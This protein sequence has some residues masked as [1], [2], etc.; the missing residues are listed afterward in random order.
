MK[1]MGSKLSM[2]DGTLG[3]ELLR[4][5][6]PGG[7]F[8]DLFAGSGVVGRFVASQVDIPV[9]SVDLMRFSSLL[10]GATLERTKAL[11]GDALWRRWS[12][13]A[14]QFMAKHARLERMSMSLSRAA[15]EADVL[16]A[17]RLCASYLPDQFIWSH[18]GGYYFSPTQALQLSA[19]Y[20]TLPARAPHRTLALAAI[21][22]T[23]S[24]ASASPGHTA[25]P[26]RPTEKLLPH[27]RSAWSVDVREE[28]IRQVERMAAT[29]AKVRGLAHTGDGLEFAKK[30]IIA[31]DLVFCDPPYS[32]AQYG[33]FYHV[34]EGI[35]VGGWPAV[36][37]AG[38]A[39]EVSMR[40]S[41]SFSGS[42]KAEESAKVLLESLA[43]AGATVLWTYPEG[44]RSNRLTVDMIRDSASRFFSI[45]EHRIPMRHSTL[46]GSSSSGNLRNSRKYLDEILFVLKPS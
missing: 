34:L 2:L 26:F 13:A 22:R 14:D 41:S 20:S 19:F 35:A 31:K 21:I 25:Q 4:L 1:Y 39:P 38:R 12:A 7:R 32:D 8:I 36:F 27:I 42:T 30:R 28:L 24:K 16:S 37:G 6:P 23:A 9:F 33:R 29:H 5:A 11:D 40:A 3:G 10:A 45:E 18:Y 44:D 17:R 46:G 15:N 43:G